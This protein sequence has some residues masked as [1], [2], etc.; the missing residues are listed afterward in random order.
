MVKDNTQIT[1]TWLYM[2]CTF[3]LTAGMLF[4]WVSLRM[5]LSVLVAVLVVN[6]LLLGSKFTLFACSAKM[7]GGLLNHFPLSTGS[8]EVSRRGHGKH[9]RRRGFASQFQLPLCGPLSQHSA[10]P[11]NLLWAPPHEAFPLTLEDR[12]LESSTSVAFLPL[13]E[14]QVCPTPRLFS[15]ESGS[16]P[17]CYSY[18]CRGFFPS[19]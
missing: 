15:P 14:P 16:C 13:H 3:L 8:V 2:H 19:Y 5:S 18:T 4:W 6:V 9:C 17:L 12:I 10:V 7:G 1:T 11:Q